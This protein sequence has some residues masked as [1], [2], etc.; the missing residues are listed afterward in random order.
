MVTRYFPSTFH[1]SRSVGGRPA[2]LGGRRS[3][4]ARAA[5]LG[6][7]LLLGSSAAS[8]L[9]AAAC[10]PVGAPAG[11][12]RLPWHCC[13]CCRLRGLLWALVASGVAVARLASA[14]AALLVGRLS[15]GR[16]AAAVRLT[17]MSPFRLLAGGSVVGR[18]ASAAAASR[19]CLGCSAASRL[20][21]RWLPRAGALSF[22]RGALACGGAARARLLGCLL[23]SAARVP[24]PMLPLLASASAAR[25]LPGWLAS[26]RLRSRLPPAA[27]RLPRLRC[28]S[29][30]LV[31]G[32]RAGS[33]C[34]PPASAPRLGRAAAACRLARRRASLASLVACW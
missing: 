22:G 21:L 5:R 1:H 33:I 4:C 6:C 20:S 28:R 16:R 7:A 18:L 12:S 10:A 15:S 32:A 9:P 31:R 29:A 24:P 19:V 8:C 30:G 11:L 26:A 17:S 34:L 14:A 2:R 13:A 3:G 23:A 25:L 27:C